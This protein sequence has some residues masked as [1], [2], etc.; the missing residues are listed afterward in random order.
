MS[1]VVRLPIAAFT[2]LLAGAIAVPVASGGQ[3]AMLS[4]DARR[5][6]LIFVRDGPIR[7]MLL[8]Y[9]YMWCYH[10]ACAMNQWLASQ[11]YVVLSVNGRAASATPSRSGTPAGR[12]RL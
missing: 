1:R 11:G 5:R 7:Q 12:R 10:T 2:L 8:G 4:A 6:A 3:V 9:C